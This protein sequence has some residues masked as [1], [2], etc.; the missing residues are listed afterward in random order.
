[1]V[2]IDGV[3]V[4]SINTD[5]QDGSTDVAGALTDEKTFP[6]SWK[7]GLSAEDFLKADDSY[8]FFNV[9]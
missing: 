3:V 2:D 1:M 7:L 5:G 4:A 8:T 9:I 6:R